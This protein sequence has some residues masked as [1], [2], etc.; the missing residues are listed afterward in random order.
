MGAGHG[1]P[2][3]Q[4]LQGKGS[5]QGSRGGRTNVGGPGGVQRGGPRLPSSPSRAHL[6]DEASRTVS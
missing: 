2:F 1:L 6:C 4:G 5:Q 3:L